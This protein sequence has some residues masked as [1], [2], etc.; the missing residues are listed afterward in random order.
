MPFIFLHKDAA[1]N[2]CC[3]RSTSYEPRLLW[4]VSSLLISRFVDETTKFL[5]RR[6]LPKV[7][8]IEMGCLGW[9]QKQPNF[10]MHQTDPH[11]T[12]LHLFKKEEKP[13]QWQSLLYA[14]RKAIDSCWF[15]LYSHWA[16]YIINESWWNIQLS[17]PYE[18]RSLTAVLR[19]HRKDLQRKIQGPWL[20]L[21]FN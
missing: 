20:H 7:T 15:P 21:F 8:R 6:S 17:P 3:Q 13:Q 14:A 4:L 9:G 1:R 10:R 19:P 12:S 16:N 5:R 2:D 11:V 18:L